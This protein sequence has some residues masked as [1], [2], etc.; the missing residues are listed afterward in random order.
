MLLFLLSVGRK[1]W[2]YGLQKRG[3]VSHHTQFPF[4][5]GS[6]IFIG[7]KSQDNLLEAFPN[8]NSLLADALGVLLDVRAPW[9]G[10]EALAFLPDMVAELGTSHGMSC[11]HE[12][13]QS[14]TP[15][16]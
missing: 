10:D 5:K 7:T 4:P 14:N 9:P 1:E 15:R 8:Q 2:T 16:Q 3:I 11:R 12:N 13:H 6:N